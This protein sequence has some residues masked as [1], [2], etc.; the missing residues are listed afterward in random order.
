[1]SE[2]LHYIRCT[3]CG[4]LNPF[5]TEYLTLCESCGRK[6]LHNFPDWQKNHPGK[7]VVDFNKEVCV[8]ASEHSNHQHLQ[9]PD[10]RIFNRSF[11]SWLIAALFGLLLGI[12]IWYPDKETLFKRKT[13]PEQIMTTE[14]IWQST[15]QPPMLISLPEKPEKQKVAIPE[16]LSEFVEHAETY[17]FQPA[18]SL[19]VTIDHYRFKTGITPSTELV[20]HA[21]MKQMAA[22]GEIRFTDYRESPTM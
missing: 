9:K 5:K 21:V 6:L 4:Y 12:W 10:K 17:G 19:K 18:T 2:T 16:L 7:T 22:G 11:L 15:G 20:A 13:I 3:H 1:M 14:W 8:L